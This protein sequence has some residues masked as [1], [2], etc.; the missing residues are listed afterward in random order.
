MSPSLRTTGLNIIISHARG[1]GA[2]DMGSGRDLS[3]GRAVRREHVNI[4]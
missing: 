3:M 2:G 4:G 1:G